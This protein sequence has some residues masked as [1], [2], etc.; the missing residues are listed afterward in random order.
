MSDKELVKGLSDRI[1]G[2]FRRIVAYEDLTFSGV[3]VNRELEITRLKFSYGNGYGTLRVEP[4]GICDIPYNDSSKRLMR[5][6][7]FEDLYNK[8]PELPILPLP[9]N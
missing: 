3:S 6:E 2:F 7:S 8:I 5:A 9:E 4:D 1:L